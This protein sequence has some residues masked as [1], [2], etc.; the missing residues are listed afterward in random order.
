MLKIIL[1][2]DNLDDYFKKYKLT[3]KKVMKDHPEY[4][5]RHF[6]ALN[7]GGERHKKALNLLFTILKNKIQNW[8]D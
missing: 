8:W 1:I 4:K 6:I 5:E 3:F 7:I 2:E